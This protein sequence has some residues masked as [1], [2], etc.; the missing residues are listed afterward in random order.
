ML[1]RTNH[2]KRNVKSDVLSSAKTYFDRGPARR[3][4]WLLARGMAKHRV[5]RAASAMAFD[6]FLAAI[7]MLALTGWLFATV[8]KDS[9]QALG[10]TSL[11]L[12]LT[13]YEVHLMLRKHFDRFSAGVAPFAIIGSLWLASS[14]FHTLMAVF[15]LALHAKKRPW[16]KK[17]LIAIL[18]VLIAISA[19]MLSAYVAVA[20][21]GGPQVVLEL[22]WPGHSDGGRGARWVAAGLALLTITALLAAFFRIAVERPEVNRRVWPGALVTVAIGGAV[23]WGFAAYARTLARFTLFYGSLA[24]V[25]IT[26]AW[27]WIWCAALLLGAELNAQLEEDE[28][29]LAR[30]LGDSTPDDERDSDA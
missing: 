13:P 2:P 19:F 22:M 1:E 15:E 29:T 24:A 27:L 6:L 12:D 17:R 26:M 30:R 23:S 25:I 20:V 21:A 11:L 16:W 9:P 10:S 8:L 18:C 28:A 5:G 7:P 3:R 14:A 4:I